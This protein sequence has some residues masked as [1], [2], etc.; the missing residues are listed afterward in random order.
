MSTAKLTGAGFQTISSNTNI[1]TQRS[2]MTVNLQ[3]P[4]VA[5]STSCV[6]Y[7]STLLRSVNTNSSTLRPQFQPFQALD[8]A[9]AANNFAYR[10][11]S[12]AGTSAN[13]SNGIN[14]PGTLSGGGQ[15]PDNFSDL[16]YVRV[17]GRVRCEGSNASGTSV[18]NTFPAGILYM[19]YLRQSDNTQITGR[20]GFIFSNSSRVSSIKFSYT[21]GN[22]YGVSHAFSVLD[23]SSG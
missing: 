21:A 14:T 9:G 18:A 2:S 3:N 13:G 10:S 22:F 19:S 1:N 12:A 7:F 23:R 15:E 4:S 5:A 20:T 17:F 6:T 16:W 11:T 8:A